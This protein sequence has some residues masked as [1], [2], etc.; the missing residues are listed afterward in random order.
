MSLIEGNEAGIMVAASLRRANR[1]AEAQALLAKWPL[2]PTG[3]EPG[4]S[5]VVFVEAMRVKAGGR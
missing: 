4:F 3:P 1:E 5:S 2:P